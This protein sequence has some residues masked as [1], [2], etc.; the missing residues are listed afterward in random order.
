MAQQPE[1]RLDEDMD[2]DPETAANV[3]GGFFRLDVLRTE[4]KDG[5]RLADRGTVHEKAEFSDSDTLKG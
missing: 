5:A 2:I 4:F 1:D 3:S